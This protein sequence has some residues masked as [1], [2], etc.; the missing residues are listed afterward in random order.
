VTAEG[1]GSISDSTDR[2]AGMEPAPLA[3]L[4]VTTAI[5]HDFL[6]SIQDVVVNL[7]G[8]KRTVVSLWADGVGDQPSAAMP[9]DVVGL[10]VTAGQNLIASAGDV[11]AMDG[12]IRAA[13]GHVETA[14]KKVGTAMPTPACA[15][16]AI[17]KDLVPVGWGRFVVGGGGIAMS[18]GVNIKGAAYN[19]TGS[20]TITFGTAPPSPGFHGVGFVTSYQSPDV[21]FWCDTSADGSGNMIVNV[22]ARSV[23]AAPS[24]VD[25]SF[26]LVALCG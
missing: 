6:N 13:T 15:F 23:G 19:A 1:G 16:G 21:T 20:Y 8:G 7:Y 12:N 18:S 22:H 3:R 4:E 9:G 2:T 17:Y 25:G 24:P 11:V 5:A 10:N 14:E 26:F